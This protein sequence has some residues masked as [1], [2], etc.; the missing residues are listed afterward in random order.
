M[1]K[2]IILNGNDI[3][4][5]NNFHEELARML[6]FPSYYD[7]TLDSLLDC[8]NTYVNPNLTIHWTAHL[9]SKQYMGHEFDQIIE[10]FDMAKGYHPQFE[11][12]LS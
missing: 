8:L 5:T 6:S 12:Y 10:V 7:N 11:Y 4:N 9:K 2:E 3:I 1:R